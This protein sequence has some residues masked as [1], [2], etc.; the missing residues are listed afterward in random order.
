MSIA[1]VL[2][3]LC[4]GISWP[5]S[6]GKALRTR[7]VEGKS[8]VFMIVLMCGYCFGIL[9]KLQQPHTDWVTGLYVMNLLL[10]GTDL[11]LYYRFKPRPRM[12]IKPL[13]DAVST[14]R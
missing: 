7:V 8:P 5:I 12:R 11:S 13:A 14:D 2:M 6:I 1:E 10:V 3:L 9:H 4:F